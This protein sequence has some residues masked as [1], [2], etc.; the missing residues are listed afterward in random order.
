MFIIFSCN[1]AFHIKSISFGGCL[2]VV[3][4]PVKKKQPANPSNKIFCNHTDIDKAIRFHF[5]YYKPACVI[6]QKDGAV[7]TTNY[8]K[9]YYLKLQTKRCLGCCHS[10]KSVEQFC[11]FKLNLIWVFN[12]PN[13][14]KKFFVGLGS[15]HLH[16]HLVVYA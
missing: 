13:W 8:N 5:F 4:I 10:Q 6:F 16:Q 12:A 1:H 9:H 11:R 14:K 2:W 15:L 3:C 7:I